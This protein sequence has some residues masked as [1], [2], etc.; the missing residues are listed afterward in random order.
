MGSS[1]SPRPTEALCPVLQEAGDAGI[2]VLTSNAGVSCT[3]LVQGFTGPN[4]TLQ[5]QHHGQLHL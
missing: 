3:D 5:A 2:P 1:S 4:Y